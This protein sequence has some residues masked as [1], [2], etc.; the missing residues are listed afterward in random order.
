MIP[1]APRIVGSL[2]VTHIT[3]VLFEIPK[4]FCFSCKR[5]AR[6]H[7]WLFQDSSFSPEHSG[8]RRFHGF[9]L[10]SP[11]RPKL[12][13][14]T[15]LDPPT[16]ASLSPDGD[17]DLRNY[18]A[19]YDLANDVHASNMT[20][21]SSAYLAVY[22]A[23]SYCLY[24]TGFIRGPSLMEYFWRVLHG[25][26]RKLGTSWSCDSAISGLGLFWLAS[27]FFSSTKIS[28]YDGIWRLRHVRPSAVSA[29]CLHLAFPIARR[30]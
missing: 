6:L 21:E 20:L 24:G 14:H 13:N 7:G 19:T 28:L 9:H 25:S 29:C 16:T 2:A 17:D 15:T 1:K 11:Y 8:K 22:F 30:S 4:C 27:R 10:T 18:E 23:L 3:R 12:Q 26:G 5:V